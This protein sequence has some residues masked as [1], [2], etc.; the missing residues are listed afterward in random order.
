M[1]LIVRGN[2]VMK[3]VRDYDDKIWFGGWLEH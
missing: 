2:V 1:S 3:I